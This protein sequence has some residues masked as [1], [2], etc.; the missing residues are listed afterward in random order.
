M[1]AA[2]IIAD[3]TRRLLK[4]SV[5]MGGLTHIDNKTTHNA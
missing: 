1:R 2:T 3:E 4:E 5:D